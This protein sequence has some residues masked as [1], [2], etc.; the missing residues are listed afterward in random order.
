[1]EHEKARKNPKNLDTPKSAHNS[2]VRKCGHSGTSLKKVFD[3]LL[4]R[5]C[6]ET[7]SYY[8]QRLTTLAVFGS[9]GRHVP[10]PDSD[11]DML[12][13]AKSLPSGRIARVQEFDT[14]ENNLKGDLARASSNGVNTRFSPLFRTEEEMDVGGL[15]FLDMVH[16]SRILFD[17][18]TFFEQY[19]GSLESTLVKNKAVRV[20]TGSTWHWVLKPDLKPGEE[21]KI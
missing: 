16:D 8:G 17:R 21:I 4:M 19:L 7:K 14:I 9:V 18:E 1:M 15:I 2:A 3:D 5:L 6:E 11:I 20:K 10:T 13:I 12:I